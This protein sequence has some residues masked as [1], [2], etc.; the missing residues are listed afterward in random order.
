[1]RPPSDPATE[2]VLPGLGDRRRRFRVRAWMRSEHLQEWTQTMVLMIGA[3]WGIYTFW[4][5]DIWLPSFQAANLTLDIT[6]TPVA[7]SVENPDGRETILEAKATNSS[8]KPVYLLGN[9]WLLSGL[10]RI[11]HHPPTQANE[12][13]LLQQANKVLLQD[14]L[15]HFEKTFPHQVDP[16]FLAVGRLFDDDVIQPGETT[17]R[18]LLVRIPRDIH[19]LELRAFLPLLHRQP[20]HALFKGRILGWKLTSDLLNLE[21]H[22]CTP[23]KQ[24]SLESTCELTDYKTIDKLIQ[25]FDSHNFLINFRKQYGLPKGSVSI[26]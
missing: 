16:V 3:A 4:Y 12:S 10:P 20:S 26:Q 13:Q 14:N 15:S 24:Q 19:A 22:L 11:A 1:M 17:S 5:K 21:P 9:T 7:G 8:A 18:S 25:R 2:D 23:S 6:I